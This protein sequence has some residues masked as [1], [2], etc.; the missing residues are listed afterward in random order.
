MRTKDGV[1]TITDLGSTNGT[2]VN[3]DTIGSRELAD[4]DKITIGTTVLEF[5]GA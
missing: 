2:R 5:R 3:G 1:T 4:G